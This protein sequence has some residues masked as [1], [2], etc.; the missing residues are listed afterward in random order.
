MEG[1][2]TS[3]RA[4]QTPYLANGDKWMK[5]FKVCID[6]GHTQAKDTKGDP[7]A[8]N[9]SYWESVAALDIALMMGEMF[10]GAGCDVVYTRKKGAPDLT[11]KRRCQIA[12]EA[13]AD[14][15]IS[16][17]LNSAENKGATGIEVLRYGDCSYKTKELADNV[18]NRLVDA[19]GFRNRGV[20]IRNNL[21]VL[22]HTK[23]P[24]ILVETGF[25]SNDE[26]CAD[27]FSDDCQ[28]YIAQAIFMATLS[29][30]RR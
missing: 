17:H 3:Q 30:F 6:P 18:Q 13:N 20:K 19:T 22:K 1:Q 15:F 25:I 8:V 14:V 5:K 2:E 12:N 27:L 24:A 23:M 26:Q 4:S 28:F 7:G 9:G 16:I 10:K 21:Y 29:T 11:L